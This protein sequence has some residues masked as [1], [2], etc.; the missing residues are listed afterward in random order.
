MRFFSFVA[1]GEQFDVGGYLSATGLGAD[2]SWRRGEKRG[3]GTYPNCGFIKY[4]GDEDVLDLHRQF[5]AACLFP[6]GSRPEL[7]DRE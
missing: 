1:V 3:D 2:A 5:T 4:L 6:T 7:A